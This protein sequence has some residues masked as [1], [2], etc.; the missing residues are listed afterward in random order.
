MPG[1]RLVCVWQAAHANDPNP[2]N[3]TITKDALKKVNVRFAGF[4]ST[5]YMENKFDSTF[6]DGVTFELYKTYVHK[7][8][9]E[10]GV[11]EH[12]LHDDI[13]KACWDLS[14]SSYKC[15]LPGSDLFRLW[16][17]ANRLTQEGTYPPII[18]TDECQW[19]SEKIASHLGK[20]WKTN[21]HTY[22]ADGATFQDLLD[23]LDD[24]YFH[25]T[26]PDLVHACIKDLHKWLVEEV[27]KT[28]W[29]YK[30][31]R[32]Q[33]NWTNWTKRWFVLK[34]GRLEYYD[35]PAVGNSTS[36]LKGEVVIS[37]NTKLESLPDY[38]GLVRKLSGR[39][40]V[41]NAHEIEC[42]IADAATGASNKERRAWL[43]CLEE[44]IETCKE[45]M[46]PVQKLLNER[47]RR[48]EISRDDSTS[49]IDNALSA[50][51]ERSVEDQNGNSPTED[52]KY[53]VPVKA[54]NFQPVPMSSHSNGQAKKPDPVK[55]SN[56]SAEV[57]PVI[58]VDQPSIDTEE[59]NDSNMIKVAEEK[60][61]AVFMKIDTSGNGWIDPEE[62]SAFIHSL[63]L[64]MT[65][66]EINLVFNTV[67]KDSNGKINFEEFEEYFSR[68]IMDE[69]C[70]SACVAALRGA[71]LEA[72]RNGTGTLNF[73]EFAEYV[74]EKKRSIRVSKI[75]KAFKK[76]DGQQKG[77]ITF[78]DFR[79]LYL[80]PGGGVEAPIPE[81]EIELV[82]ES[83]SLD[84]FERQLKQT[85]DDTDVDTLS[86]YIRDRWDKFTS[87]RR[88]GA[89]GEV[90]MKGGSGMV[91]DI[92]PGDYNLMDIACFSDLPPLVPKCT[93]IKG[94]KWVSSTI[95]G[96]SGKIVFPS[97]FNKE[98]VTDL[99]TNEHLRYYGCSFADSQQVKISLMYR[100][101][102]QDFTYENK[103]LEDY[104]TV[105]NGGAGIERHDFSHLDCPLV[106]DSGVFIMAKL[107]G[108]DELHVTGFRVPVRHTLYI[109]GG[110]I[111][112][113][114]YLKGTWRT[115]LSDETDIDHVH[116]VKKSAKALDENL[117][118]FKF[119]FV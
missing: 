67:D 26:S 90:V 104:V 94:V 96:I 69:N 63:G 102:I 4:Q 62:F 91:A 8:L 32:K 118:G 48:R 6:K 84:V 115:M 61:K 80:R 12:V 39:F 45:G 27:M 60:L 74:W 110:C 119:Q 53:I 51:Y 42:E 50:T 55:I 10:K 30:R 20:H 92:V 68:Y 31:T 17:V 114:D 86:H 107:V 52:G 2:R 5:H 40:K 87:F 1:E 9:L 49:K 82:Q 112:S 41:S 76:M 35:K 36:R 116:L 113:N 3:K 93:V 44:V 85:Y 72:D 97:D 47:H 117:T 29:M 70:S 105:S 59:N 111:H 14:K 79:D 88:L 109:P 28:G 83:D 73:H 101:G 89:S 38:S 22:K 99:A 37:Q 25:E 66:K 18:C 106:E 34:P 58:N 19:L 21:D 15:S 75:L 108:D 43:S 71:F 23:S 81:E 57:P 13:E 33:A 65:E 24:V 103:Y 46:T 56:S 7:S 77:E 98:I 11:P 16:Q 64:K 100:H 78:T 95:P 54:P